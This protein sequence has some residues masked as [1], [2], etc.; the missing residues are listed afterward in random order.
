MIQLKPFN[1]S[2]F[3]QFISWVADEELLVTIAGSV[4]S[5]PL[6]GQQLEAYLH[7]QNSHAFKIVYIA[8][9]KTIGHAELSGSGERTYKID[10][11]LIGDHTNRGKGIGQKV[12]DELL[13]QAFTKMDAET[14]ELNVFDWNNSAIRCYEKTGFTFNP[15]KTAVFNVGD[16]KWTAINMSIEKNDWVR[17]LS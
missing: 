12:I 1:E 7:D 6:T 15:D 8:S 9:N 3:A 4:F 11:L 5:F 13:E 2:D 14:V 10:K 17:L 16:K